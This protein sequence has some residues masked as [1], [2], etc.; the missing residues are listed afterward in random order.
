MALTH[1]DFLLD[2]ALDAD[3]RYSEAIATHAPKRTRWTLTAADERH[4]EIADAYHDKVT[5]DAAL[6]I[7]MRTGVQRIP[8][9]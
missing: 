1:A 2:R 3:R 6:L 5:A 8:E 4:P 9:D 7:Y